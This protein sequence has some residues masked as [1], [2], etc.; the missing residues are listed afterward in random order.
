MAGPSAIGDEVSLNEDEQ[1][2]VDTSV[3]L[4]WIFAIV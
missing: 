4:V 3:T 1:V 2:N